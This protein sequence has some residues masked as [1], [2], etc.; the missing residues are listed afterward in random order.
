MH[1]HVH[2]QTLWQEEIVP[3]REWLIIRDDN[4]DT[5]IYTKGAVNISFNS[6]IQK[7]LYERMHWAHKYREIITAGKF[8]LT[9]A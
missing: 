4:L 6:D 1:H 2:I 3:P 8:A 9:D 5:Y 7:H